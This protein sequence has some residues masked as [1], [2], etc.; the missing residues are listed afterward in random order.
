MLS[1]CLCA[2][3]ASTIRLPRTQHSNDS[4]LPD[5][6]QTMRLNIWRMHHYCSGFNIHAAL[7]IWRHVK[8]V[9][10]FFPSTTNY[11]QRLHFSSTNFHGITPTTQVCA[12][13]L[14]T[15]PRYKIGGDISHTHTHPDKHFKLS[16]NINTTPNKIAKKPKQQE[17]KPL[18]YHRP[19][20]R[21]STFFLL[22]FP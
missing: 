6:Y 19:N 15:F 13:K 10:C 17:K 2:F 4:T 5:N 1:V 22:C 9:W 20:S 14:K 16:T 21:L 11:N 18:I 3:E 12:P 7:F 8:S